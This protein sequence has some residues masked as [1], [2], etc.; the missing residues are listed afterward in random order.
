MN[1]PVCLVVGSFFVASD[2]VNFLGGVALPIK[3][4]KVY[5]SSVDITLIML[6]SST[7]GGAKTMVPFSDLSDCFTTCPKKKK[8]SN[9][10]FFSNFAMVKTAEFS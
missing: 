1:I 7:D 10:V 6:L 4:T 2:A 8:V 5:Y 9:S 3:Q